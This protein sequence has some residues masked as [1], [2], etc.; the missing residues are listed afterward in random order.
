MSCKYR[1][2][3][4][5]VVQKRLAQSRVN[6]KINGNFPAAYL[7][8]AKYLLKKSSPHQIYRRVKSTENKTD[9]W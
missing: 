5:L 6:V 4:G 3:H 8:S 2:V 7:Q 1:K 9:P